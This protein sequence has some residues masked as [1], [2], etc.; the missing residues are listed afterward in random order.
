M[1]HLRNL[2][3]KLKKNPLH[4]VLKKLPSNANIAFFWNRGL[5]DI[6][7]ELYSFKETILKFC[8]K[9]R[10]CVITREDL[11]EGF[12]LLE[13]LTVYTSALLKRKEEED[14]EAIFTSLNLNKDAFD[15][16]FYK[17]D[18][19]YWVAKEKKVQTPKLHWDQSFETK[20]YLLEGKHYAFLHLNSETVYGFE[21]NLSKAQWQTI[22]Q[23]LKEKNYTTVAL[24]AS[25]DSFDLSCD[26]DLRGKTS[27]FDIIT[28]LLNSSSIFIGPDSGLLNILYFLNIQTP[29]KLI[30]YFGNTNVGIL[31]NNHPSPNS[32][33]Q[34]EKVRVTE[35]SL[36]DIEPSL[37]T[38]LIPSHPK[39][40]HVLGFDQ[41]ICSPDFEQSLRQSFA[42]LR[43][44]QKASY[45]ENLTLEN[46]E[47]TFLET[48]NEQDPMLC[49]IILAGGQATRLK[50][51]YPK[52]LFEIENLS[53]IG[54]FC[55][56]IAQAS[57]KFQ[58][59]LKAFV[60]VSCE[61]HDSIL[62]HLKE[63]NFFW[64]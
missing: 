10:L 40:N 47:P 56:K 20:A 50:T 30:S 23:D 43:T 2:I 4:Q 45:S 33:L 59:E 64:A 11:K 25:C 35:G 7:L 41:N 27:L 18:P 63:H 24:G 15:H 52:A 5:G 60:I 54:H 9:A 42:K 12:M 61:G 36:H 62:H 57:S 28:H 19:A 38:K 49:P 58:K 46:V 53:L 22:L 48:L 26:I 44:V 37:I 14:Y 3:R 21:K 51:G 31:Q 16:I 1:G 29:L 32:L 17:P 6:P 34:F 13:G 55:K 39:E 8:P